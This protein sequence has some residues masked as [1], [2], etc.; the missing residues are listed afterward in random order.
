MSFV[1]SIALTDREVRTTSPCVLEKSYCAQSYLMSYPKRSWSWPL[2]PVE[3]EEHKRLVIAWDEVSSL[4]PYRQSH[5]V[6]A[7]PKKKATVNNCSFAS[8]GI[9][10]K[11]LAKLKLSSKLESDAGTFIMRDKYFRKF[12][13]MIRPKQTVIRFLKNYSRKEFLRFLKN[14]GS[15]R[16]RGRRKRA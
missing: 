4:S 1:Q 5:R 12:F 15:K 14:L 3:E 7:T 2:L 16:R 13:L 10:F 6:R 11:K 9:A 8:V